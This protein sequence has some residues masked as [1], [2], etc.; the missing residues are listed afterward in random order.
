MGCTM[1]KCLKCQI[2]VAD[3]AIMCPLCHSVLEKNIDETTMGND[4]PDEVK[5]TR[6]ISKA[7]RWIMAFSIVIEAVLVFINYET[8]TT[9]WWSL[10]CGL[11]FV[12]AY[13]SAR[14]IFSN[15]SNH[16][17]KIWLQSIGIGIVTVILD[18]LLGY[19]GW[20][21]N[22]ALPVI[23]LSVQVLIVILILV[24]VQSWTNYILL[25]LF[26]LLVSIGLIGLEA[27]NI[28]TW[29]ILS[30]I[31]LL[32]SIAVIVC[33]VLIGGKRAETEIKRKFHM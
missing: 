5:K 30:Q 2:K 10:I 27:I 18:H 7:L 29:P 6:R 32:V 28:V 3:D 16:V 4:Y 13:I 12:Y 23:V 1:N 33:S 8:Y 9:T 22:F 14:M 21:V 17:M 20:S 24:R 25:Q 31:A 15:S 26:L 19:K 11:G